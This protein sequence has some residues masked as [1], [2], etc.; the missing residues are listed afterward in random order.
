MF[1]YMLQTT[2]FWVSG[3]SCSDIVYQYRPATCKFSCCKRKQLQNKLGRWRFSRHKQD[4]R[5]SKLA[6]Y[7]EWQEQLVSCSTLNWMCL[8]SLYPK[9]IFLQINQLIFGGIYLI[10]RLNWQHWTRVHERQ[11]VVS[12][13]CIGL[14]HPW[15][16]LSLLHN[17]ML[18][19]SKH[20]L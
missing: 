2:N 8:W 16:W 4:H 18:F 10:Y 5:I 17:T 1:S 6:V 15:T 14:D 20:G 11:Q 9:D 19:G 13:R 3:I 7:P 12:S